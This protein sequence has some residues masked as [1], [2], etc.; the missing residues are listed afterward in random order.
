MVPHL[1][2]LSSSFGS[3]S[4]SLQLHLEVLLF[5]PHVLQLRVQILHLPLMLLQPGDR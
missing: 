5:L 4:S 3:R 2:G 1:L